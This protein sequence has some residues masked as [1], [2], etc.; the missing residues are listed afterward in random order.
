[1]T[2]SPGMHMW[3]ERCVHRLRVNS[4]RNCRGF[5]ALN[6]AWRMVGVG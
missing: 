2:G 6:V 4:Y 5:V 3:K 1:M